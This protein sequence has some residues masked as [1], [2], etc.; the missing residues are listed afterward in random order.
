MQGCGFRI[1][2]GV[3]RNHRE[4]RDRHKKFVGAKVMQLE[5]FL[6]ALAKIHRHQTRI[7]TDAVLFMH[8]RIADIDFSQIAQQAFGTGAGFFA[9]SRLFDL[10]RIQLV[11][12]DD[13]ETLIGQD[14]SA[15]QG[16]EDDANPLFC[17]RYTAVLIACASPLSGRRERGPRLAAV[18][19][20]EA[21]DGRGFQAIFSEKLGDGLTPPHAVGGDEN[22][23]LEGRHE[24][25]KLRQRVRGAAVDFNGG[26]CQC[27]TVNFFAFTLCKWLHAAEQFINGQEN[28]LRRQQR[29][30]F[31]TA[32]QLETRLGIFPKIFC[33]RD[34]VAMLKHLGV[35]R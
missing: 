2:T 13:G 1:G 33:M 28:I 4:L 7:A 16:R 9:A 15:L 31:I 10:G 19:F 27:G 17:A 8:H 18:E 35:F 32:H 30:V 34:H 3:A 11:F 24:R 21:L 29:P 26:Q 12:G 6:R 5:K 14:K 20:R 23:A 25:A 22:V